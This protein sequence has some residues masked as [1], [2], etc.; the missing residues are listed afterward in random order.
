M[1]EG[2]PPVEGEGEPPV[3][4][5]TVPDIIGKSR[6]EAVALLEALGLQVVV[7]EE[8]SKTPKDEVIVQ[9]PASGAEATPGDTITL[10]VSTGNSGSLCGCGP[11]AKSGGD[12]NGDFILLLLLS[13]GLIVSNVAQRKSNTAVARKA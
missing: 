6:D 1:G 12:Y 3:E 2:E 9:D 11:R 5:V 8:N 10:T 4:P 7:E 13:F